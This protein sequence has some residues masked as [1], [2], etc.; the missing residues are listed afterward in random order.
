MYEK[1]SD[2]IKKQ[3]KPE[4]VSE[5]PA[6][7]SSTPSDTAPR[8]TPAEYRALLKSSIEKVVQQNQSREEDGVGDD[9]A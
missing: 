6:Q 9:L 8:L 4:T 2:W 5:T 3:Q 7:E 1:A